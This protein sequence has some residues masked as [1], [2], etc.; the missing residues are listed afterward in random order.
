MRISK[1]IIERIEGEAN[2]ELEWEEGKVS[3]ARVKF[4]NFRG[5]EAILEGRHP[6]DALVISPRVCGICSH[7]HANAAVLALE[8]CYESAGYSFT[9]TPKANSIRQIILNAEKIQNHLKWFGLAVVP[10]LAKADKQN[11][12]LFGDVKS[13]WAGLHEAYTLSLRMGAIF[14]GQWPHGSFVVPGGV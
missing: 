1:E 12:H 9:C 10:E 4:V 2:L 11:A 6:M 7:S 3:D 5:I 14:S 8:S 13:L